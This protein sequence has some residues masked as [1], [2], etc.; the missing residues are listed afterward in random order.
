MKRFL[1]ISLVLFLINSTNIFSQDMREALEYKYDVTKVVNDTSITYFGWDFRFL[2]FNDPKFQ[3]GR[4]VTSKLLPG[5]KGIIDDKYGPDFMEKKFKKKNF[6]YDP[7]AIQS[8]IK[9]VDEK[10]LVDIYRVPLSIDSVRSI[11]KSYPVKGTGLGAVIIA[12]EMRKHDIT[13]TAYVT[14]FSM[15][16]KEVLYACKIKGKAGDKGSV[17][18]FYG[19]GVLEIMSIYWSYYKRIYK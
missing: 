11:V 7:R 18:R 4:D 1:T 6:V 5:L 2:I 15:E 10:I 17:G 12:D 8:L 9:N 13:V 16:S 14:I 19:K 3:E